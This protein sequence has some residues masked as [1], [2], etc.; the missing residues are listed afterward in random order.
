MGTAGY[1]GMAPIWAVE[2]ADAEAHKLPKIFGHIRDTRAKNWARARVSRDKDTGFVP[3]IVEQKDRDI[4]AEI[5]R[6]YIC[7]YISLLLC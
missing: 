6:N 1:A 7:S 5:V 4:V 2:D 3:M